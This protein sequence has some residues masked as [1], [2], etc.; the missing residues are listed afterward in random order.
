MKTIIIILCTLFCFVSVSDA[1]AD[2]TG[3]AGILWQQHIDTL[4]YKL[5]KDGKIDVTASKVIYTYHRVNDPILKEL[6]DVTKVCYMFENDRFIG[7]IYTM[8][9]VENTM[10]FMAAIVKTIGEPDNINE[11]DDHLQV[12]WIRKL[13][14]V[15]GMTA[16]RSVLIGERMAMTE[17]I[18]KW[19]A[20]INI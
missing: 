8:A 14:I 5:V 7:I 20:R 11:K 17:I 18:K 16:E 1:S 13:S 4:P 10:L 9:D 12:V 15:F 6:P 19:G 3:M 2:F